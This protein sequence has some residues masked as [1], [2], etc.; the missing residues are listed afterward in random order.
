MVYSMHVVVTHQ[1]IVAPYFGNQSHIIK[2]QGIF[3]VP[4]LVYGVLIYWDSLQPANQ[5]L[6]F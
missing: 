3:E 5:G 4:Y 6:D 2:S 1:S